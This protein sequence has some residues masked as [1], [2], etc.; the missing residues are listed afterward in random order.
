M[1]RPPGGGS[2]IS[3]DYDKPA[4]SARPT[5]HSKSQDSTHPPSKPAASQ[6]P[7]AI[8]SPQQQQQQN[9]RSDEINLGKS[10]K[11]VHT[12]SKV[13]NPPGG[14]SSISFYWQT[15]TLVNIMI[16]IRQ[17]NLWP[18]IIYNARHCTITRLCGVYIVHHVLYAIFVWNIHCQKKG[19]IRST[20]SQNHTAIHCG[21]LPN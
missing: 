12:S 17:Y 14:K 2:S 15:I 8:K 3:F 9:S 5:A 18:L 10:N 20:V 21:L 19:E 1:I 7:Q 13:L 4:P 6:T 16:V 11:A